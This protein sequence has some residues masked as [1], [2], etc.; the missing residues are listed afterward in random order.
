LKE[1]FKGLWKRIKQIFIF[2]LKVIYIPIIASMMIIITV[3]YA[4][5]TPIVWIILGEE[6]VSKYL[7]WTESL[8]EGMVL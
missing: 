1:Y 8:V 3:F 2:V 5:T 4:I 7:L 6:A